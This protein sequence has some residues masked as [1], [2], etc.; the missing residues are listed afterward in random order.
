LTGLTGCATIEQIVSDGIDAPITGPVVEAPAA[1]PVPVDVEG[2]YFTIT[3]PAQQDYE[4]SAVGAIEYCGLDE[5]DRAVCAYGSLTAETRE[6][7]QQRGR[8]NIEID[9]TGFTD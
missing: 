9:P 3:G 6:A 2:D 7:A 8:Q 5:L 1:D 4:V